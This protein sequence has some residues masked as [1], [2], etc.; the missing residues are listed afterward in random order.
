MIIFYFNWKGIGGV[1][2][3]FC[4]IAT[5]LAT[6]NIPFKFIYY[7]NT[8]LTNELNKKGI[9][10]DIFDIESDNKKDLQKFVH[11]TDIIIATHGYFLKELYSIS[12]RFLFWMVHPL[13]IKTK[14]DAI[15]YKKILLGKIYT[16]IIY[17]NGFVVM[18]GA[19][20]ETLKSIYKPRYIPDYLQI[21]I[22]VSN[23]NVDINELLIVNVQKSVCNISYLG[24]AE[25]WKANP[26]KNILKD[27][28]AI[29][30]NLKIK[31]NF[32][33]ITDNPQLF[34][35]LLEY[36]GAV[37][38]IY[39]K[40]LYG[41]ALYDFL[42]HNIVINFA[43]GT[44]CLESAQLGIPTIMVDASYDQYP[45]DYKYRWLFETENFILGNIVTS[46]SKT[47]G[48]N[49]DVLIQTIIDSNEYLLTISKN[50]KNYVI[51]NH[52]I[53]KVVSLLLK[54]IEKNKNH[55][56]TNIHSLVSIFKF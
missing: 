18:D 8:W 48:F 28:D 33:I 9:F 23:S 2:S 44:S 11:K 31:F 54:H 3:L 13:A 25:N 22:I 50:C 26:V 37:K 41:Q 4:N 34:E 14:F 49:L 12:P 56:T 19:C 7:R 20:M 35:Q 15:K 38:I 53:Q 40:E 42:T 21:P 1:Q 10:F 29:Q 17:N 24:R 32:H 43:M 5:E 45:L 39:H 27:L 51:E 46:N 16:S 55:L 36:N 52:N 6:R 30:L 47:T